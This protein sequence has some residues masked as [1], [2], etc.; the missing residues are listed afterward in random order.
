MN[1]GEPSL[2]GLKCDSG[3]FED[4]ELNDSDDPI[5]RGC[6]HIL[7]F[8]DHESSCG[9]K[10]DHPKIFKRNAIKSENIKT[11]WTK[12]YSVDKP[13]NDVNPGTG[14]HEHYTFYLSKPIDDKTVVYDTNNNRYKKCKKTAIFYRS[15]G[16]QTNSEGEAIGHQA[17]W[18]LRKFYQVIVEFSAL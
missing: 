4:C 14:D 5:P 12:Y 10:C 7:M 6:E 2:I 17:W 8:S 11:G 16:G 3:D 15:K 13:L 9:S 18:N 1:V